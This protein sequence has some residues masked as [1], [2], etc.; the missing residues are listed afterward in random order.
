MRLGDTYGE[1]RERAGEYDHG[2]PACDGANLCAREDASAKLF[3]RRR[4]HERHV[5]ARVSAVVIGGVTADMRAIF[6]A[7]QL[8]HT[9]ARV[10]ARSHTY[11]CTLRR[12]KVGVVGTKAPCAHRARLR[13][14]FTCHM[15]VDVE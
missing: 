1:P 7:N 6:C 2:G 14:Q 9:T 10:H 11:L 12:A 4:V 3:H 15:P 5:R 8:R 13:P